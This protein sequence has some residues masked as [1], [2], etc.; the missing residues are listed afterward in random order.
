MTQPK[1]PFTKAQ[2]IPQEETLEIARKKGDLFIGIPTENHFQEKRICLTPD[3][4]GAIVANGHKILIEKG[5]G[6][7][8]GFTAW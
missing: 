8:A 5:A 1:S 4:V 7:Q 2:L 3:A 6:N